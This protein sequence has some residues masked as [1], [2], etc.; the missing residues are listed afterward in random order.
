MGSWGSWTSFVGQWGAF[1]CRIGALEAK[2]QKY[3]VLAII[4]H[5]WSQVG[6]CGTSLD[7]CVRLRD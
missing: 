6:G 4:G 7:Y 3:M 5:F 1:D 2:V